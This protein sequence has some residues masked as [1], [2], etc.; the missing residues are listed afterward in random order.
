VSV[1]PVEAL[2]FFVAFV[3]SATVHE[4]AH[5]WAAKRGG[6]PTAYLGGQVSLDPMPH[7][8]R[9]PFGMLILPLVSVLLIGWPIGF[10][11]APYD[12]LW[13]MRHP[14][15]AAWMALAGPAA[16]LAIVLACALA[17]R[18]LVAHGT[19]QIPASVSYAEVAV[20]Y[21]S[22]LGG[23][24]ALVVSILFSLNLVLL[25]L[26]MIPLPPLDGSGAL[27]LLLPEDV[28]ARYQQAVR[29]SGIGWIGML[30]V[31]WFFPRI[32]EPVFWSV[33]HL[34]YPEVRYG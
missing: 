1:D 33:V 20:G 15:R 34:L 7:I 31:F 24:L 13:A 27:G 32:F 2:V 22:P 23:A 30:L 29:E 6:D 18:L 19:F 25:V 14:R 10:A 9:E 21:G 8:R 16:N 5:A 4:A 17:I 3:F 26:N 11:S 28:T 12:P